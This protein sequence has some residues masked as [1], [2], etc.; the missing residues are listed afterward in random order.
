MLE[1]IQTSSLVAIGVGFE[2]L[3]VAILL[4]NQFKAEHDNQKLDDIRGHIV[5]LGLAIRKSERLS[6]ERVATG[7][8]VAGVDDTLNLIAEA[9]R[10]ADEATRETYIGILDKVRAG[11]RRRRPLSFFALGLIVFG[12]ILQVISTL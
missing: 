6:E 9:E 4:K 10:K 11:G 3:G 8:T 5:G 7:V 1:F 2:L 12:G